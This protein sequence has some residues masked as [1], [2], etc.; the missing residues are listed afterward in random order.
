MGAA[1]SVLDVAGM[2]RLHMVTLMALVSGAAACTAE[3]SE[4]ASATSEETLQSDAAFEALNAALANVDAHERR[5]AM[6]LRDLAPVLAPEDVGR[7]TGAYRRLPGPAQARR[8]VERRTDELA[9]ALDRTLNEL[10]P[11][12]RTQHQPAPYA[13]RSPGTQGTPPPPLPAPAVLAAGPR[14]LEQ[15]RL[16]AR[17]S[18]ASSAIAFVEHC[19]QG[20]TAWARALMDPRNAGRFRIKEDLVD[21]ILADAL[22]HGANEA[23]VQAATRAGGQRVSGRAALDTLRDSLSNSH[24]VVDSLLDGLDGYLAKRARNLDALYATPVNGATPEITQAFQLRN[25]RLGHAMKAAGILL[26]LWELDSISLAEQT[27]VLSGFADVARAAGTGF[28]AFADAVQ[29]ARKTVLGLEEHVGLAAASKIVSRITGGLS[30]LL[31]A[32]DIVTQLAAW[33]GNP[34]D[35]LQLLSDGLALAGG[36]MALAGATGPAA[37]IVGVVA[38][39]LSLIADAF[40]RA[41]AE[42]VEGELQRADKRVVLP[43]IGFTTV[44]VDAFTNA[45]K[46]MLRLL[47]DNWLEPAHIRELVRI[48]PFVVTADEIRREKRYEALC[49]ARVALRL[50]GAQLHGML[51]AV[52]G[53]DPGQRQVRLESFLGELET[54]AFRF[55]HAGTFYTALAE[56]ERVSWSR[57]TMYRESPRAF[58]SAA[59]WVR[60]N[61][62]T[63][64]RQ[65]PMPACRR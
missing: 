44:E 47:D 38:L 41:E 11:I 26:T 35:V 32:K 22:V 20:D 16:L 6:E 5:L 24:S 29:L 27:D 21:G 63:L 39:G 43:S 34:S 48:D 51:M 50:N 64:L 52:A 60:A 10:E 40:A 57:M 4:E 2:K 12:A 8:D 58:A 37:V 18:R 23:A 53:N 61:D 65:S 17:S 59:E 31:K 25:T 62:S 33:R 30:V 13:L 19:V 14:L 3:T 36:A 49:E 28:E 54:L 56:L 45:R 55:A 15:F 1:C 9:S 42:R 7:Y 46:N